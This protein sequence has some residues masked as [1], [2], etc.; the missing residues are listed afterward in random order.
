MDNETRILV[1]E[2]RM[3]YLVFSKLQVS[4]EYLSVCFV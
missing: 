3:A 1:A 2:Y 4:S